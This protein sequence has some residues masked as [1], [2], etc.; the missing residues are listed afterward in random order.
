MFV[1]LSFCVSFMT[2]AGSVTPQELL[3]AE[4]YE[5]LSSEVESSSEPT[6]EE[7]NN[8]HTDWGMKMLKRM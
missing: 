1:Y 3:S 4:D 5:R 6:A 7:V 8:R 2:I